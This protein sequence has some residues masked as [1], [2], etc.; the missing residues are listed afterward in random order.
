MAPRAFAPVRIGMYGTTGDVRT[1]RCVFGAS[2]VLLEQWPCFSGDGYI[3]A[4]QSCIDG[5]TG[6]V[7]PEAVRAA[8]IAAAQEANI[9]FTG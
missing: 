2:E 8:L 6:R 3:H 7:P 9:A 4:L 1:V 5:I